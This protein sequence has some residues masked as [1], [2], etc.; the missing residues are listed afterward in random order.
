MVKLISEQLK[1]FTSTTRL[2]VP[3]CHKTRGFV[4]K[5]FN[6]NW[7][8]VF[9]NSL[10]GICEIFLWTSNITPPPWR[11]LSFLYT[12]YGQDSGN[13]SCCNGAVSFC[14]LNSH[15]VR[16]AKIKEGQQFKF[17]LM[18][19]MFMLI[20]FSPP[21]SY[22]YLC[23]MKKTQFSFLLSG[24]QIYFDFPSLTAH[25]KKKKK[26]KKKRIGKVEKVTFWA[27]PG[28]VCIIQ[29]FI[30]SF[31]DERASIVNP[32]LTTVILNCLWSFRTAPS[33]KP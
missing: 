13:N 1:V 10:M 31:C 30:P 25:Q 29:S 15:N 22:F 11:F 14:F 9:S 2:P 27:N 19:L 8:R 12:L 32:H 16:L 23:Q 24:D 33:H 4:C 5:H 28:A 20:N 26:K 18:L 21:A 17:F 6:P 7:L 3:S